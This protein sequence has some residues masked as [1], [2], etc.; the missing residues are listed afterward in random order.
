MDA[1]P[2]KLDHEFAELSEVAREL[3]DEKVNDKRTHSS[4]AKAVDAVPAGAQAD[5]WL[6]S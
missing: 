2:D 5:D 4:F 1:N 6:G 3:E